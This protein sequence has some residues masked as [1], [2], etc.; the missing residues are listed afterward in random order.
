MKSRS[1]KVARNN[2]SRPKSKYVRK[3]VNPPNNNAEQL[4]HSIG[5]NTTTMNVTEAMPSTA[6]TTTISSSV[7]IG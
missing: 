6:S 4:P 1:G 3:M 2:A 7:Q 5:E